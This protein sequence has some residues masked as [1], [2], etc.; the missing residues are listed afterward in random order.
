MKKRGHLVC[1]LLIG[2]LRPLGPRGEPSGIAKSSVK[3][4]VLLGAEGLAGDAQGDRKHHGGPEKALHHYPF[5]HYACWRQEI[6]HNDVLAGPGAFGENISTTGIDEDAVA[7]GDVF[8]IGGAV[9]EVSQGRQPCWKLNERFGLKHMAKSVQTT[10]R[11][12]WYY[13]VLQTGMVAAGDQIERIDRQSPDWTI[14]R[15]RRAFYVDTLN[16]DE[17]QAIAVLPRL[18]ANWRDYATRRLATGT[19]EDWSKRLSG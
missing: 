8:A 5:E 12:G 4:P 2:G 14:G 7:I 10:G 16:R 19:V 1:E 3:G 9:V 18:A 17:L 13:R 15:I 11:T 6:G